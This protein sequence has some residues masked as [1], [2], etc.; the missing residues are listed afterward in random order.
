MMIAV[1]C[2]GSDES[3]FV[4]QCIRVLCSC[5]SDDAVCEECSE[6]MRMTTGLL[7][8]KCCLAIVASTKI[9]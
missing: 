6:I 8:V 5:L 3:M 9:N 7:C 4:A 2:C 1:W